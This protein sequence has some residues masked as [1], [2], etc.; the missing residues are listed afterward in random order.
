MANIL[1]ASG[2]EPRKVLFDPL[3]LA[4]TENHAD[5]SHDSFAGAL[6]RRLTTWNH[7]SGTCPVGLMVDESFRFLGTNGLRIADASV[8]PFSASGHTDAAARLVG[9]L[10]AE[11][12]VHQWRL[13][14]RMRAEDLPEPAAL[15]QPLKPHQIF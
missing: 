15:F 14:S 9:Y 6:Q 13:L 1:T 7:P 10:A 4:T 8:L 11:S 2:G 5:A 3:I 12:I